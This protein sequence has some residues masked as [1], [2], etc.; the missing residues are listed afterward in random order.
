MQKMSAGKFHGAHSQGGSPTREA[1]ACRL[2]HAIRPRSAL[3]ERLHFPG[4]GLYFFGRGYGRVA[5]PVIA[6]LGPANCCIYSQILLSIAGGASSAAK[7]TSCG[8][9]PRSSTCSPI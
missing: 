3:A 8:S 6:A 7:M 9:S 4:G 1:S 5:V 2:E